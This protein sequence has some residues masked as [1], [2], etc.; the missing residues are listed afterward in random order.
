MISVITSRAN[1]RITEAAL[2]KD[3]KG[4]DK[5]ARFLTYGHK[6][7]EEAVQS[8]A[9]IETVFAL[10]DQ[11]P[12]CRRLL[13]EEKIVEVSLPVLEKL[14][15]EQA[16]EG[17]VGVVGCRALLHETTDRYVPKQKGETVCLLHSIQDPGNLGTIL[18]SA[19][20]FGMNTLLLSADCADL[21][22]PR[23]V[24]ASMG[25]VFR[26]HTA[27]CTD[28]V[29]T[30]RTLTEQGY[31]VFA[32]VPRADALPLCEALN[33]AM[34]AFMIGNEGHGLP[35]DVIDAAGHASVIP[36]AF[37]TESLNAAVAASVI[38]YEQ[39]KSR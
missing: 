31:T 22:H 25:A 15:T 36:M 9:L 28:F 17:I 19:A 38:L 13:P 30:V 10:P 35:Q 16:P 5:T 32:A 1:P 8:D 2:L 6:L 11:I 37:G 7:L 21:T 29:G 20:A 14:S 24:R 26:Q 18:R 27:L 34:P 33:A 3:K 39:G 4:R 12:L 23:A